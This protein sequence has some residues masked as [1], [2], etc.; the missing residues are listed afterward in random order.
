MSAAAT[1]SEARYGA[2]K[3]HSCSAPADTRVLLFDVGGVLVQLSGIEMMLDW[4]GNTMTA[5]QFWH[6]WLRSEAVR[7]FETGRIEAAEFATAVTRDFGIAIE[8]QRFL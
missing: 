1:A 7:K 6:L 4:L 5:E 2:G 3:S 8:P